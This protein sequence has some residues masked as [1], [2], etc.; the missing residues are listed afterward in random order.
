[1]VIKSP[2]VNC[3]PN[4]AVGNE[5]VML[6]SNHTEIADAE[7]FAPVSL[8]EKNS[9]LPSS[10]ETAPL[11]TQNIATVQTLEVI[12][13]ET[14]TFDLADS[15]KDS[16][17]FEF[18]LPKIPVPKPEVRLS[19]PSEEVRKEASVILEISSSDE[20]SCSDEDSSSDAGSSSSYKSE[21]AP[22]D[23]LPRPRCAMLPAPNQKVNSSQRSSGPRRQMVLE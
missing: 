1:M 17:E 14:L 12:P 11:E 18:A 4:D 8:N 9:V 2:G 10:L 13:L 3:S 20:V 7:N 19:Q 21:N 15:G 16:Q 6:V 22:N 5:N 23:P